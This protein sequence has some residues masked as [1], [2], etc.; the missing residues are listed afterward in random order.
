MTTEGMTSLVGLG[1]IFQS[2]ATQGLRVSADLVCSPPFQAAAA[3]SIA[4][5]YGEAQAQQFRE[6]LRAATAFCRAGAIERQEAGREAEKKR[7]MYWALGLSVAA[8]GGLY[9]WFK[10][11]KKGNRKA[12][13]RNSAGVLQTVKDAAT[14]ATIT[15]RESPVRGGIRWEIRSSQLDSSASYESVETYPT[16]EA[17]L[18]GAVTALRS[19]WSA[20][21]DRRHGVAPGKTGYRHRRRNAKKDRT[22][23]VGDRVGY[24]RLFL[25]SIG[26]G[27]T[28][29]EWRWK[30]TV[31]G[32]A[33]DL[34]RDRFS[35]V[36]FDHGYEVNINNF[37]IAKVGSYAYAHGG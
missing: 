6:H 24:T 19:M 37:N 3:Q 21:L 23:E 31:V 9:L 5:R 22:F 26:M 29:P 16:I 28:A 13:R 2:L 35:R 1:D 14:G 33:G 15:I 34:P 12:R 17:A 36:R 25:K 4:E 18:A 10:L 7:S 30:G 20:M 27:P 32:P 8:L 11:G